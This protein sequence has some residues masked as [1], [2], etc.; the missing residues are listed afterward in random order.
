ML[1]LTKILPHVHSKISQGKYTALKMLWDFI[2]NHEI[3]QAVVM[4]NVRDWLVLSFTWLSQ[5]LPK[6][7]Y[8]PAN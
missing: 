5:D 1:L 4:T 8:Q 3:R 6:L 7:V 2:K